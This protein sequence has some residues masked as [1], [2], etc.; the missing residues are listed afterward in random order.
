M[1]T[2]RNLGYKTEKRIENEAFWAA[3]LQRINETQVK[4]ECTGRVLSLQQKLAKIWERRS[5][6]RK[7]IMTPGPLDY[8]SP[9]SSNVTTFKFKEHCYSFTRGPR[10]IP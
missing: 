6:R 4:K 1:E 10:Y 3:D 8:Q 5:V 9:Y 2:V 7:L